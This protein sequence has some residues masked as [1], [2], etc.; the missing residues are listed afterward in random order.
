MFNDDYR[1]MVTVKKITK[2]AEHTNADSLELAFVDGW[3]VIVKKGEL[4]EGDL[5]LYFEIDSVLP[6]E[7]EQRI[8]PPDSKITLKKSRVKTIKIRKMYSQGLIVPISTFSDFK[9]KIKEGEDVT[10][11]LG[12]E[13][14]EEPIKKTSIL[15]VKKQKKKYENPNFHKVRKPDNIKYF[16]DLFIGKQVCITEKLHGTSFVAGWVKRPNHSFFDKIR[17]YL[18]GKYEFCYRS[19][20]VQLQK[21]DSILDGILKKLGIRKERGYYQ[22]EINVNVYQ[23]AVEK[24]DLKNKIPMGYEITAEIVGDG[25]QTNYN[26]G[27]KKDERKMIC[28][29]VRKNGENIF[30]EDAVY[31][32]SSI[33]FEYVPILYIGSFS[34]EIL[35]KH[36]NGCSNYCNS[37]KIKEGC[38]VECIEEGIYPNLL[39]S[40]SEKYL[41]KGNST[42]FH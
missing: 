23:E 34:K 38:V 21:R 36:T 1:P 6:Q 20:N 16:P 13:K 10:K 8:F 26:Y 31:L 41:D 2:I 17:I 5:I 40:I 19:M 4:K 27:C 32:V 33:G 28:F 12:V 14:Y 22:K 39:K 37:Q 15:Y 11:I 9:F 30:Y 18:F 29:G 24:Y 25:I 42:D 7:I 3:Q 35:D